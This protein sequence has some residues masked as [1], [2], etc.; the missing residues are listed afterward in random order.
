MLGIE[1][2]SHG[3]TSKI[4]VVI[5]GVAHG[6]YFSLNTFNLIDRIKKLSVC[7]L[8]LLQFIVQCFDIFRPEKTVN[9]LNAHRVGVVYD[10]AQLFFMHDKVIGR[11]R[12]FVECFL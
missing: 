8:A 1:K 6:V 7:C 5:H 3:D 9:R 4:D 11:N 12:H 2:G 10:R